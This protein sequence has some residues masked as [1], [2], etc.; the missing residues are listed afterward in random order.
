M[1]REFFDK[2]AAGGRPDYGG[3]SYEVFMKGSG[4][5]VIQRCASGFTHLVFTDNK[6][7]PSDGNG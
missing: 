3:E 1:R 6:S 7:K 5:R 4:E 2:L